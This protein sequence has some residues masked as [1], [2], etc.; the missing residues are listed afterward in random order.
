M[1][2]FSFKRLKQNMSQSPTVPCQ[3]IKHLDNS[4]P[5]ADLVSFGSVTRRFGQYSE[6][7]SS[8]HLYVV[9]GL[10]ISYVA[11]YS[12]N[13]WFGLIWSKCFVT[14][15]NLQH[16]DFFFFEITISFLKKKSRIV[17]YE[18]LDGISGAIFSTMV[19]CYQNCS[20]PL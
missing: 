16:F 19:F 18:L 13:L 1:T 5:I 15:K 7:N 3:Q 20:D 11:I 4:S 6:V 2:L 9:Q 12:R 14:K 17:V 8:I 10:F